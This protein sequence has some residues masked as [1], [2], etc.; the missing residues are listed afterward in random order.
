MNVHEKLLQVQQKLKA[1]KGQYNEFADFRYR[2]CEDIQEAAKPLLAEVKAVLLISDEVVLIGDR[3]YIKAT[4]I[5]Q[6]TESPDRVINAAFARETE[7]KPK[8]D[9]AQITGSC[10]SYA[11]KYALNGLFCIDDAK[12]PDTQ[13]PE[14]PPANRQQNRT[15]QGSRQPKPTKADLDKLRREAQRTGTNLSVVC[16]RYGVK[17]I[18]DLELEQFMRAMSAFKKMPTLPPPAPDGQYEID[19]SGLDAE[20][21]FR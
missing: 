19:L 13:K 3:F 15:A 17:R 5:F 11:R 20:L 9:A 8:M 12:D 7:S 4:A 18:E 21:P 2:S 6:D 10:S 1:P 14:Q 16:S